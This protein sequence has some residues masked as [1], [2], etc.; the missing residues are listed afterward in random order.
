MTVHPSQQTDDRDPSRQ[1]DDRQ[2]AAQVPRSV[3][4]RLRRMNRQSKIVLAGAAAAL[5]LIAAM[6]AVT[7]GSKPA[8]QAQPAAKAFTVSMLGHSGQN[9]SLAQYA[10][11]PLII[12][13]FAS[14]CTPCKR[15]TPLLAKFY[16]AHH[17]RDLIIGIDANDSS[18]PAQKF[19]Q[20]AGVTYPVGV[21]PFPAPVTTSYGVYG[22]PQ[23]FFLNAKHHIVKHVIGTV[24]VTDLNQGIALMDARS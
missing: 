22:L 3:A 24:T 10:G 17:G 15:E 2:A 1:T 8:P 6:T 13:F 18:G 7:L 5:V 12:N 23:T 20:A 14:W 4:G 19:V 16:A 11:R 21:D 9:V